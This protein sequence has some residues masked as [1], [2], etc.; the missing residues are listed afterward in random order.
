M[1]R[2][3][4]YIRYEGITNEFKNPIYDEIYASS[5]DEN[6]ENFWDEQAQKLHWHKPYS[7]VLDKSDQYLHR[8]FPDGHLN[9]CYNAVDRHVAEGRGDNTALIYD[10][11]YTGVQ[12]KISYRELQKSCA[13]YASIL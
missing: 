3:D 10:S 8:W 6:Q 1:E 9:L 5:I 11:A 13:Q 2:G 12:K 7:Q 4:G